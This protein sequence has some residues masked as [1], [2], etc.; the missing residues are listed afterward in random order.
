MLQEICDDW[1][2]KMLICPFRYASDNGTMI[3][4]GGILQYKGAG[5]LKTEES[6]VLPDWRSD[7]VQIVW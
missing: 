6:L 7:E 1:K 3:A 5:A 2:M 4:W